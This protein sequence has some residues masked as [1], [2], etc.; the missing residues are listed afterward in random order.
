MS[1]VGLAVGRVAGIRCSLADDFFSF[2]LIP[3]AGVVP[4]SR[5]SHTL[6]GEVWYDVGKVSP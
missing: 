6:L 5:Y 4:L 3:A 1:Y 2:E